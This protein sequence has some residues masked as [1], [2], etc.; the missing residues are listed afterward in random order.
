LE[1]D[2]ANVK[3]TVVGH[4][5]R[6]AALSALQVTCFLPS[7]LHRLGHHQF[8]SSFDTSNCSGPR[9]LKLIVN[10]IFTGGNTLLL[11]ASF[12]MASGLRIL[13]PIKR[14]IDYAVSLVLFS[15]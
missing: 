1:A 14:V 7:V 13:V 6:S 5:A 4:S 15:A 11:I 3:A 8:S 2:E 12:T 9:S 10:P